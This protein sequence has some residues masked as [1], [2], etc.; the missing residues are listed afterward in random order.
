MYT[1]GHELSGDCG[2][3]MSEQTAVPTRASTD[4]IAKRHASRYGVVL[5]MWRSHT[6]HTRF[7]TLPVATDR[8]PDRTS[9][10]Y[11]SPL[12]AKLRRKP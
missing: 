1:K 6:N 4:T 9:S 2:R 10:T 8:F 11:T 12:A 5:M 3:D 7:R